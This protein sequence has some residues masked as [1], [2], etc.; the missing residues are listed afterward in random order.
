MASSAVPSQN[1]SLVAAGHQAISIFAS[2]RLICN[3]A[4]LVT[5]GFFGVWS[6]VSLELQTALISC[7]VTLLG[8]V[9]GV[10][11]LG[12]R[13]EWLKRWFGFMLTS[14]GQLLFLIVA[15]NL[16]WTIAGTLGIVT[17]VVTNVHAASVWFTARDE[18]P[19]SAL[20]SSDSAALRDEPQ[21]AEPSYNG[22]IAA[23]DG[24]ESQSVR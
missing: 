5:A 7:Y 22:W 14:H 4:L 13:Q 21:R 11:S 6:A 15:G 9:L 2:S 16:A 1:Q 19:G 23:A 10:F 17:A 8:L 24:T 20:A 18:R 3:A 12:A